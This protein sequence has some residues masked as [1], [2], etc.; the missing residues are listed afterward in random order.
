RIQKAENK[1]KAIA[2]AAAIVTK[3]NDKKAALKVLQEALKP[4]L[5]DSAFAH[6]ALADVAWAAEEPSVAL[7]HAKHALSMDRGSEAA[8]QR[9]LEYGFAVDPDRALAS[10]R[11]FARE[12]P[13]ARK[14]HLMLVAK[15]V[16]QRDFD[17][18]LA[19]IQQMRASA[20]EDFD[21]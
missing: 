15:L 13:K 16:E 11:A 20:P 14:L 9:V 5:K 17:G 1:D 4:S 2:Q 21:L 7:D 8:A 19:L 10:A 6:L 12:H 18:A 3:M